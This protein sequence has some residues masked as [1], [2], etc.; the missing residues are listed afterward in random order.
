[1]EIAEPR[2]KA[3]A[4]AKQLGP[5]ESQPVDTCAISKAARRRVA[6][7][8]IGGGKMANAAVLK[9]AVKEA[10]SAHKSARDR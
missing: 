9:Q 10:K 8:G 1:M 7:Y 4:P 2:P 5:V 6:S 3:Y